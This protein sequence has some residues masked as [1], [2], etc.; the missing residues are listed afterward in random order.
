[1]HLQP[2]AFTPYFCEEN[3]FKLCLA[4]NSEE[5]YSKE[6]YAVFVSNDERK[7]RILCIGCMGAHEAEVPTA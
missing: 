6:L 2:F 5:G 1:M 4:L 7:V 3:I